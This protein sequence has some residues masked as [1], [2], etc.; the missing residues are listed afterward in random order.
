[1]A[2]LRLDHVLNSVG[3]T[4]RA[5]YQI[6]RDCALLPAI[7]YAVIGDCPYPLDSQVNGT[8]TVRRGGL[9]TRPY[10]TRPYAPPAP[11]R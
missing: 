10:R 2:V 7:G 11:A 6:L 1:M 4:T 8:G 3:K 5:L 9:S